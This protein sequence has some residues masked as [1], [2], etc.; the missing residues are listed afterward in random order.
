MQEQK[1]EVVGG[2]VSYV[3]GDIS[4]LRVYPFVRGHIRR[5]MRVRQNVEDSWIID[6]RQKGHGGDDLFEDIPNFGLDL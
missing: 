3:R 5:V 2:T 4:K 1:K 6:D